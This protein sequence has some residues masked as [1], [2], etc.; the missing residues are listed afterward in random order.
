LLELSFAFSVTGEFT[1]RFDIEGIDTDGC[2]SGAAD[3]VTNDPDMIEAAVELVTGTLFAKPNNAL[4]WA[5]AA[6]RLR[7]TRAR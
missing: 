3:S 1:G 5:K 7:R 6:A 2:D 4:R